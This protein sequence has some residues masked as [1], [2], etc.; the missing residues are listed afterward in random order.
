MKEEIQELLNKRE[1]AQ[2]QK[3]K[4]LKQL[5]QSD[6]K[7]NYLKRKLNRVSADEEK[8]NVHRKIVNGG[9]LDVLLDEKID[10]ESIY[11]RKMTEEQYKDIALFIHK[12]IS[13]KFIDS[14]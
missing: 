12:R 4:L 8:K 6:K 9:I 11:G 13:E 1:I 14:V 7:I 5:E 2:E 10:F 3:E